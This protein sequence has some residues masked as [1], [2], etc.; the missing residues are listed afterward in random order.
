LPDK[1]L[2]NSTLQRAKRIFASIGAR[3]KTTVFL[4][5]TSKKNPELCNSQQAISNQLKNNNP[6]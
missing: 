1:F 4:I 5:N 2:F 3:L 6:K